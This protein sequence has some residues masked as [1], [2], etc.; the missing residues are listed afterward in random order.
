MK[1]F[2]YHVGE[3]DF[4]DTVPFGEGWKKAKE[5]AHELDAPIFRTIIKQEEDAYCKG[6]IFLSKWYDEILCKGK[7]I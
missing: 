1:L 4:P 7:E 3:F 6:G 5:K 2:I